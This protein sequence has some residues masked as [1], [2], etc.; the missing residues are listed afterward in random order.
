MLAL[1]RQNLDDSLH[2]ILI[3]PGR[4]VADGPQSQACRSRPFVQPWP[5]SWLLGVAE[6]VPRSL[7]VLPARHSP[8][9]PGP[10]RA[11]PL[12]TVVISVVFFLPGD[13]DLFDVRL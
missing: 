7:A 8:Y 6:P 13:Q 3:T 11:A 5:G 9:T 1:R 10:W 4:V 12:P 2:S